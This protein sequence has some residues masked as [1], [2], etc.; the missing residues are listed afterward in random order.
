MNSENPFDPDNNPYKESHGW[1]LILV[2]VLSMAP[3]LLG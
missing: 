1:L 3:M 2:I